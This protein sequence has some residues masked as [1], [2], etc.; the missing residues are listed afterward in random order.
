[1]DWWKK[2]SIFFKLQYW[3]H[4][5]LRHNLD[6]M[7]IEKNVCDNLVCTLLNDAKSKDNLEARLDLVDLGIHQEL[8]PK[9][10]EDSRYIVPLACFTMSR[11]NKETLCSVIQSIKLPYG[12][13]SNI[14]RSVDMKSCKFIGL[15]SHDCHILI[16]HL[17]PFAL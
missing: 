12:Y 11:E 10:E 14:A 7:H 16:E 8:H 3:E 5:S 4:L 2:K 15:K 1:M 9:L 6:V 17:L 13:A